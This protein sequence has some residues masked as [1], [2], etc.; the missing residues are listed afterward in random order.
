MRGLNRI[1]LMGNLT[2]DPEIKQ[3]ATGI[4]V[5]RIGIATSRRWKDDSGET[6]EDVQFHTVIAWSNLAQLAVKYLKTGSPAYIEGRMTY[7]KYKTLNGVEKMIPEIIAS[8]IIFLP[9][10]GDKQIIS[11]DE[12]NEGVDE[13][14]EVFGIKKPE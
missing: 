4:A 6:K 14:D 3:T 12:V 8:E 1:T 9:T 2:R 7:R 11:T 13:I 10:K 5:A